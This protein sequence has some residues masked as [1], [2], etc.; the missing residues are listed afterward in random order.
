MTGRY[1]H[2]SR[3]ALIGQLERRDVLQRYGLIWEREGIEPDRALNQDYVVFDLDQELS[4][5]PQ[6]AR[7]WRN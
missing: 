1:D 4:T 5:P 3:E 7:G 2:Y 6:D